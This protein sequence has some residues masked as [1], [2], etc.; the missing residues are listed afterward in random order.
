MSNILSKRPRGRPKK[1]TYPTIPDNY[2]NV[3]V[4]PELIRC[5]IAVDT[6]MQ[7]QPPYDQHQRD[8]KHVYDYHTNGFNLYPFI[9]LMVYEGS[10]TYDQDHDLYHHAQVNGYSGTYEQF[11]QVYDEVLEGKFGKK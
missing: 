5:N 9:N 3:K 2:P 4:K 7:S 10:S 11:M 1:I 6:F 8:K